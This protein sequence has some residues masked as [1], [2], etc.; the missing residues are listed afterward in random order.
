VLLT[1]GYVDRDPGRARELGRQYAAAYRRSAIAHYELGADAE[2]AIDAF[3]D[4]QLWGTPD[5]VVEKAAHVARDMR[6]GHLVF[7][8][9]Y[10]SVPYEQAERSM[11]L[12]ASEVAPRLRQIGGPG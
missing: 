11:R 12:F 6:V 1:Y 8:F 4:G 2:A 7:A 10:A 5:E 3:A 9:R